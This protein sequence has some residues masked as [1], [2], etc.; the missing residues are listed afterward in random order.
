M[1]KTDYRFVKIDSLLRASVELQVYVPTICHSKK[2]TKID[3][4]QLV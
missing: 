2:L 4:K 1:T 3:G